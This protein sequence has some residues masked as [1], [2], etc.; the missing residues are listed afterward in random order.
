[1]KNGEIYH[2][3]ANFGDLYR[4]RSV[5]VQVRAVPVQVVFCFSILTSVRIVAIT[6]SFIIR[7]GLFKL[8]V[9]LDF[10]ENQT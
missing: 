2:L 10:K 1:M 4:Y 9:K 7:F 3:W 6:C 5:P 8:L